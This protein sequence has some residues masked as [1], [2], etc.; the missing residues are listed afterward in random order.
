MALTSSVRGV[1][2]RK[3]ST[4]NLGRFDSTKNEIRFECSSVISI[5]T[6]PTAK[7]LANM[8]KE[9]GLDANTKA[10]EKILAS[11]KGWR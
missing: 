8:M 6:L 11:K 3:S 2:R 7:E 5:R 9:A 1:G 10:K 4:S